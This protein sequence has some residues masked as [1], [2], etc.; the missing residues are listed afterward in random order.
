MNNTTNKKV[1]GQFMTTNHEYILQGIQIPD[2]II[3][4]NIIIIEPFAGNGDLVEF[5]HKNT[6]KN[7]IL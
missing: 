4:N 3:H 1:L 5:I 6:N 7:A 2:Y